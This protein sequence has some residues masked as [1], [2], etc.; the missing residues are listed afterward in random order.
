VHDGGALTAGHRVTG[1]ALVDGADTTVWVPAGAEAHV[2]AHGG[3]VVDL[4]PEEAT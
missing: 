2:D 3:L 4:T 1:P